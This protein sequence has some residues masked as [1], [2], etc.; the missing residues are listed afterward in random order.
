MKKG[1]SLSNWYEMIDIYNLNLYIFAFI[2]QVIL[3]RD[4]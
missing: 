1:V 4:M 3:D 2:F